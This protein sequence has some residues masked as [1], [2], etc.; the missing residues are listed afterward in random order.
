MYPVVWFK[1]RVYGFKRHCWKTKVG[2]TVLSATAGRQVYEKKQWYSRR[3]VSDVVL[4][5][6]GLIITAIQTG[7]MFNMMTL[8]TLVFRIIEILHILCLSLSSHTALN[9]A[10]V[11]C[12]LY[13]EA[14][15]TKGTTTAGFKSVSQNTAQ[16]RVAAVKKCFWDN[17]WQLTSYWNLVVIKNV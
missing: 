4:S 11:G 6:Y 5:A 10:V 16:Q 3:Y 14:S 8:H 13:M 12:S 7:G 9:P 2:Y 1:G 17:F 15:Y